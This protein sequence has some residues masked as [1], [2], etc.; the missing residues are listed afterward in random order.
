MSF[1]RISVVITVLFVVAFVASVCYGECVC[2]ETHELTVTITG[3]SSLVDVTYTYAGRLAK[4]ITP[5]NFVTE[6]RYDSETGFLKEVVAPDNKV[7]KFTHDDEVRIITIIGTS[8]DTTGLLPN[9]VTRFTYNNDDM[10][11]AVTMP[12]GV[13]TKDKPATL[14]PTGSIA[15]MKTVNGSTAK[16]K[17]DVW[18]K[19]IEVVGALGNAT[20][21]VRNS[22]GQ[23]VEENFVDPYTQI[24]EKYT[25]KGDGVVEL[26]E[27]GFQTTESEMAVIPYNEF[28][29]R[30]HSQTNIPLK[31]LH[32]NIVAARKDKSGNKNVFNLTSLENIVKSFRA[33]FAEVFVQ[34]YDYTSLDF[35]ANT[36]LFKPNS[37]EFVDELAQGLLGDKIASDFQNNE[38]FLYDKAVYDSEIEHEVLKIQ[39]KNEIIVYGK[40]PKRSIKV[41][42]YTGGTT[43]PDFVYAISRDNGKSLHL[44]VETKSDNLRMSDTIAVKAQEKLFKQIP[45]VEWR[46][47]TNV[48]DFERHLKELGSNV[49]VK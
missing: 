12:N 8:S 25:A 38:K 26:H 9:V 29:K 23:V 41:P 16:T 43:S 21:Y 30:L 10:I 14:I 44:I 42:T 18:G 2:G 13:G 47:E 17:Y 34:K 5:E 48:V 4:K 31:I 37:E 6:F 22:Q 39:P 20:T 11:S 1:Q 46:M 24:L 32:K 49:S 35:T 45:N 3:T 19:P 28:L 36:S 15:G 33:K 40:L 27:N 7:T